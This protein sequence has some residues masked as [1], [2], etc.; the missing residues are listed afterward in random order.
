MD[1]G[2]DQAERPDVPGYELLEELGRGGM[3]VVWKAW[4]VKA[5]R[6]VALK[7][8]LPTVTDRPTY[9]ARAQTEAEALARLRH[10]NIVQVYEVGEYKGLPFFSQE[11]VDGGT[12][13]KRIAQT[14]PP[15]P[16]AARLVETLARAM[17][18]AHEV[19]VIHRDLKPA[20]VLLTVS[21]GEGAP[22]QAADHWPLAA[23]PKIADFGLAKR[24]DVELGHTQ[25][26]QVMG[27]PPYMAPEQAQGQKEIG[28]AA[29]IYGLGA[30]LY[31]LL[32]GRP[33]FK[34][35]SIF[36]TL[37][38]VVANDP[39][40]PRQ[41]NAKA[42][43]DLETICL[44]CLQKDP[45][46]RYGTADALADDLSR[47]GRG[48]PILARP[49]S[50]WERGWKWAR[51][52]PARA[53]LALSL[54]LGLAAL[55]V[56]SVFYGLYA[57]LRV[58]QVEQHAK[59][60]ERIAKLWGDARD[61]ELNGELALAQAQEAKAAELFTDAERGM[62]QVLAIPETETDPELKA[63]LEEHLGRVR[64]NLKELSNAQEARQR[65]VQAKQEFQAGIN[66]FTKERLQLLF[67]DLSIEESERPK[68]RD[69]IRD[70]ASEALRRFHLGL[71]RQ[72]AAVEEFQQVGEFFASKLQ[73]RQVGEWCCEALLVW[74]DAEAAVGQPGLQP[75]LR[76]LD[77]A[78]ALARAEGLPKIRSLHA[79]RA[80]YLLATGD[81]KKARAEQALAE[82]LEPATAL[83]HFLLA[84][85]SYRADKPEQAIRN[86][87]E[88]LRLQP[89]YFAPQYLYALYHLKG[90]RWTAAEAWLTACLS[91]RHEA[92]WPRLMRATARIEQLN[93]QGAESDLVQAGQQAQGETEQFALYM[94]RGRLA[95][96]RAELGRYLLECP[97]PTMIPVQ[98][99][100][101]R[102]LWQE[103]CDHFRQAV[104][105]LPGVSL[106][107][108]NLAATYKELAELD[109]ALEELGRAIDLQIPDGR[110]Y[111]ARAQLHLERKQWAV[112]RADFKQ[113]VVVG[114]PKG[115]EAWLARA[116]LH[117][118]DLH[119]QVEEYDDALKEF[120][121]ALRIVKN[122][123]LAQ[124]RR[125]E[126]L[127]ANRH[128]IEAAQ[129]LDAY[130]AAGG[131]DN[132]AVYKMRG[133]IHTDRREFRQAVEA[134]S[135]ALRLQQPRD[136]ETLCFRGWAYLQSKSPELA[137][138]DFE[139][140]LKDNPQHAYSLCGRG[141]VRIIQDHAP[142]ALQDA[143][144]ALK[145][146]ARDEGE[147][148]RTLLCGVASIYAR[149]AL[150][151][152]TQGRGGTV[153]VDWS[154]AQTAATLV[155]Q[156]VKTLP[157][158]KQERFWREEVLKDPALSK[159]LPRER[160]Q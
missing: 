151:R 49:T 141:Q 21:S 82:R 116:H 119:Y 100:L 61:A 48:E 108:L 132:N 18:S 13:A 89:D 71:G 121:A 64:K 58:R 23:I 153:G 104:A 88:A 146:A 160:R 37:A 24:L 20:N 25:S 105:R 150:R 128:Y 41:L 70:L 33:P 122:W 125:A 149:A 134:Y 156:A 118:G 90:E 157:I 140:V 92:Y 15:P 43:R 123:P 28:P 136:P 38:Q 124:L 30:I 34:A 120:S 76:L 57:D 142:E 65:A 112:A 97:I 87:E 96:R 9:L 155:D 145:A 63:Q 19:N 53:M 77:Q 66:Q 110:L 81:A 67:L 36:D 50:L 137:I 5:K 40:P 99:A 102:G 93:L 62:L 106:A 55:T 139:E 129:A 69:A 51:R 44:K 74:A 154:L 152:G 14:L 47:F 6:V 131:A 59:V 60:A 101:V 85:T 32:T 10:P 83:D 42:P 78:E 103:A 95:F 79:R 138:A 98:S 127:R 27:S 52:H 86:C 68:H 107:H 75:A 11:F 94:N 158:E 72:E 8:L 91:R 45:S 144:A 29:D 3:G 133:L 117:L 135:Q 115:E 114:V 130:L 84:L 17:H 56:G 113:A 148:K 111:C 22:T 147:P 26:G 2:P 126:S 159:I 39:V 4:Q 7:M 12:L 1:E 31:E 80:E 109:H 16:E 35:A 143:E 46:K 73:R 54:V